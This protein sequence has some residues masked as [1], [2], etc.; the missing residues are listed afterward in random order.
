MT[1]QMTVSGFFRENLGAHRVVKYNVIGLAG[2]KGAG[3]DSFFKRWTAKPIYPTVNVKFATKLN[4]ILFDIIGAEVA[5]KDRDIPIDINVERMQGALDKHVG[6]GIG[7][8]VI[9]DTVN[10]KMTWRELAQYIGNDVVRKFNPDFFVESIQEE[11]EEAEEYGDI[12]MLTDVRYPNEA[13]CASLLIGLK[14]DE[15]TRTEFSLNT[16][17]SEKMG[18][19]IAVWS[20]RAMIARDLGFESMYQA[21]I[22]TIKSYYEELGVQ[23]HDVYQTMMDADGE[24]TFTSISEAYSLNDSADFE[25]HIDRWILEGLYD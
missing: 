19:M 14:R 9:K 6:K 2:S 3:K 8:Y 15:D 18:E 22:Y 13:K 4:E 21:C 16:P 24:L 17:E 7:E 5:Y 10:I 23:L 11:L 20:N 12:V 1:K 25:E